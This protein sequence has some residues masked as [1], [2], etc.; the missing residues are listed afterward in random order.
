M[1]SSCPTGT[2]P[3][4][5]R[6]PPEFDAY[7]RELRWAQHFALLNREEM[8]DRVVTPSPSTWIGAPSPE[9]ERIN[10]HHNFTQQETHFGKDGLGVPQGRHRGEAGEPG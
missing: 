9:A 8:M 5:P 1:A 4:S 7:I 6:A 2:S 10:C 3:T